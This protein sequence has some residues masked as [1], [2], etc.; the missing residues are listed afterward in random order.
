MGSK[1]GEPTG[2]GENQR[3]QTAASQTGRKGKE[4]GGKGGRELGNTFCS[5]EKIIYAQLGSREARKITWREEQ[6][7]CWFGL[8]VQSPLWDLVIGEGKFLQL[9]RIWGIWALS[10]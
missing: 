7:F 2:K 8:W 1:R 6:V 9:D 4:V 5:P 3:K 10:L